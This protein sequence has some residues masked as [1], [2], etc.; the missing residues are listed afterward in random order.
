MLNEKSLEF[1]YDNVVVGSSLEAI[2]FAHFNRYHIVWTLNESP[3]P[4][5]RLEEDFGL[6]I[7]KYDIWTRHAFLLGIGGFCPFNDNI[8]NIYLLDD[9]RLRLASKDGY[10]YFINYKQLH[11]FSDHNTH[12]LPLPV[13]EHPGAVKIIDWFS[14]ENFTLKNMGEYYFRKDRLFRELFTYKHMTTR[15]AV[16][17]SYCSERQLKKDE[18]PV[19]LANVRIYEYLKELGVKETYFGNSL[20]SKAIH[21]DR[22]IIHLGRNKYEDTETIKFNYETVRDMWR[23]YPKRVFDYTR[24]FYERAKL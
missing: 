24:Y 8:V 11:V 21:I 4:F 9:N 13:G 19:Y 23:K 17:I 14:T 20:L 1:N 2:L 16:T 5:E 22:E 6:G 7:N 15:R 12:D 3:Y 10:K 18:F